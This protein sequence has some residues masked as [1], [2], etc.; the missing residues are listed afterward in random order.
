MVAEIPESE[1]I[2]IPDCGHVAIF[3]KYDT[4]NS[5]LLGFIMKN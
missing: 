4:V 2:V 1:F 5:M 3:E